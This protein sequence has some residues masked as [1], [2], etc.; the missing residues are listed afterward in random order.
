MNRAQPTRHIAGPLLSGALLICSGSTPLLAQINAAGNAQPYRIDLPT[1]LQ[2]VNAQNLDVQ[3]A[4]ARLEEARAN[5]SSAM[6]KFLPWLT[7]GFNWRRHEGRTQAVD[8]TLIDADKQSLSFG[9]T[10]TAQ[11]D[12]GDAIYATLA[13][14]QIITVSDA[15]LSAQQQD[16]SLAAVN[17]YLDLLK[18]Q[19]LAEVQQQALQTSETYQQQINAGVS[20]GVVFKGDAL[21]VQTQ[22]ERYRLSLAQAE[23]QQALQATRLAQLLHLDPSVALVPQDKDL[24]PIDLTTQDN[25]V[26]Q[27]LPQALSASPEIKQSQ[28]L[29]EAAR[30]AKNGTVYGPLI[31]SVGA[32]AFLGELG[33]GRDGASGNYG[34]SKEYVFGLSWRFGPGGLFDF[35]RIKAS[36]ARLNAAELNAEKTADSIKRQVVDVHTRLQSLGEQLSSS[37][38]N[39][40]AATETLRLTRERKQLGVGIV[41][42]DIQAQQEQARAQAEY[43]TV[44]TEYNKTQYELSKLLGSL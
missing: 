2:L 14:K 10:L 29:V 25:A 6:A 7:A 3:I 27:L 22:T 18:A 16:S 31:P 44:I 13:A 38:N 9:P 12:L 28:A 20:A 19:A 15:A 26:E 35:T 4:R 39:V 34:N 8:G 11:V 5:H 24:V 42:E 36:A 33:G 43:L 41:L 40:S 17:A 32:Q 30:I 37:R 1:T 23:Q 21:R